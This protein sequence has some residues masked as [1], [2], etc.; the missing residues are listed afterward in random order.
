MRPKSI[1]VKMGYI[2]VQVMVGLSVRWLDPGNHQA[3]PPGT[4][5]QK[6]EDSIGTGETYI[7]VPC[8]LGTSQPSGAA[9]SCTPCKVGR[10]WGARSCCA[11][12][13]LTST[14]DLQ[15]QVAGIILSSNAITHLP[16]AGWSQADIRMK[17]AARSASV[18]PSA[19]I[20]TVPTFL[21][22]IRLKQLTLKDNT[23][24]SDRISRH[25]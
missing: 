1:H 2:F 21:G 9:L 15:D 18:A 14:R 25:W 12:L 17:I 6:L 23:P 7:C 3:C 8:G 19:P 5:S 16:Y 4:F 10:G 24:Q 20:R 11:V 22:A 13:A